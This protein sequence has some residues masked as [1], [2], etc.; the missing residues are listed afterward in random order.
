MEKFP[1]FYSCVQQSWAANFFKSPYG[2]LY[3]K[4]PFV[5]KKLIPMKK[6]WSCC[7]YE[8]DRIFVMKTFVYGFEIR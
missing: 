5:K 6:N 2:R 4:S 7:R 1:L 3:N 8:I